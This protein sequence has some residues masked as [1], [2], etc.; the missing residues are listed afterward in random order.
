MSEGT[1]KTGIVKTMV[2]LVYVL[3]L[4]IYP[5]ENIRS[6]F[7]LRDVA[8]PSS[9]LAPSTLQPPVDVFPPETIIENRERYLVLIKWVSNDDI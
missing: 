7:Y 8:A 6:V 2:T 9:P 1:L 4:Y 5:P 3:I